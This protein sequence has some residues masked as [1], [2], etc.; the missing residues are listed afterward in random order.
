MIVI[1]IIDDW[2]SLA[3]QAEGGAECKAN[4]EGHTTQGKKNA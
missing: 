3:L 4:T 1:V 2:W